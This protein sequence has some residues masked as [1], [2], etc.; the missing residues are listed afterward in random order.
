MITITKQ[1][2]E[3]I[4]FL[5]I[6]YDMPDRFRKPY[7]CHVQGL[8]SVKEDTCEHCEYYGGE[9]KSAE[10]ACYDVGD[11]S[12]GDI[13]ECYYGYGVLGSWECYYQ[14]CDI[15]NPNQDTHT[16]ITYRYGIPLIY[17]MTERYP[18]VA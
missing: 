9:T 4:A 14:Q 6:L 18:G 11:E 3:S 2:Q 10:E 1:E 17:R 16:H 8:F 12:Y 13:S 5:E 7:E 15:A